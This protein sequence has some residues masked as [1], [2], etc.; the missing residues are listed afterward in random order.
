MS[1]GLILSSYRNQSWRAEAPATPGLQTPV[2]AP[3][4]D[5]HAQKGDIRAQTGDL[6]A[7]RQRHAGP[8]SRPSPPSAQ[9]RLKLF[10]C[11]AQHW[12]GGNGARGRLALPFCAAPRSH[13]QRSLLRHQRMLQSG[14]SMRQGSRIHP[15]PTPSQGWTPT[16][17]PASPSTLTL[18]FARNLDAESGKGDRM[19]RGAYLQA[20]SRSLVLREA[21]QLLSGNPP[22]THSP[23]SPPSP[24]SSH[25]SASP[26]S[27]PRSKR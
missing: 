19:L 3:A 8:A 20:L 4:I 13:L 10:V 21:D 12:R 1:T 2:P 26:S 27:S 14:A 11:G 22:A 23:P 5:I 7:G 24:P 18:L 9:R 17:E 16:A 6:G 25:S 15:P